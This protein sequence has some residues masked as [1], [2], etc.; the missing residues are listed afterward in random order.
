MILID[1]TNEKVPNSESTQ[2]KHWNN[3]CKKKVI[4]V[5]VR[6]AHCVCSST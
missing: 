2:Q 6:R 5:E 1:T 4:Q 3:K